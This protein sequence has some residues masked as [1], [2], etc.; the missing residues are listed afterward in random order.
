[1]AFAIALDSVGNAYVAGTTSSADFPVTPGA[2]QPNKVAIQ[3]AFLSEL[4]PTGSSVL[5]STYLGAS[6]D[7]ARGVA[8]DGATPPNAYITGITATAFPT[9][10]G[11]FQTTDNVSGA[12]NQDGFVAKISPG[13][14]TGVFASPVFLAFGNQIV[15]TSSSAKTITLF[16]DSS[17]ALTGI[18]ISFTGTNAS[19]FTQGTSTCTTT[20][21]AVFKP[22]TT[23]SESAALSIADSDAS[24]PQ[25]VSLTGTGTAAPAAVFLAPATVAFGNQLINT[26]SAAQIV[27]LTNNSSAT[28]TLI[29][30]NLAGTSSASFS[31][32]TTCASSLPAAGTCTISVTFTPTAAAAATATLTVTDSDASSPQTAALTGTGITSN[33]DFSLAVSPAMTSVAAG[34][35]AAITVT[36]TGLN[37]FTTPVALTCAGAPIDSTCILTPASVTPAATGA[38]S[39]ASIVTAVRTMATWVAPPTG[40]FRSGPRHP[41]AIWPVTFALFLFAVWIVRRQPTAKKLAWAYAVLLALSVTSCSGLPNTGTPAGIY[42]ITITGTSGT[43]THQVTVSLTVT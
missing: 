11:A 33:P 8:L 43:L 9:T 10:V 12:N 27:T 25:T 1:L 3:N 36:V 17:T 37:G 29:A 31:Q 35:T 6:I 39:T 15:N 30:V 41:S 19:D 32:T 42:T 26:T 40:S 5:F 23:S 21:A 13:A 16:N 28:V 18:A 22:S 14:V 7:A 38:A 34:S 20:L 24:S 4:S 2:P